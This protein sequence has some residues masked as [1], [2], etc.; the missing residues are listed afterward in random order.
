VIID[1]RSAIPP[2]TCNT[3]SQFKLNL[4]CTTKATRDAFGN[5]ILEAIAESFPVL[6]GEG[7]SFSYAVVKP[8]CQRV[9]H[10]HT[11]PGE[12]AL[13][14]QGTASIG[15]FSFATANQESVPY[16]F[17]ASAGDIWFFPTGYL[18]YITNLDPPGGQDVIAVLG[19]SYDS[20]LAIT[21]AQ[22]LKP[23]PEDVIALS[24]NAQNDAFQ[25]WKL[26]DDAFTCINK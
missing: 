21:A 4:A 18:Q 13:V 14:L 17:N 10:W 23:L 19:F 26:H 20:I 3:T 2:S 6:E 22:G 1:R 11:I 24:L 8:G 16:L 12:L 25:K 7:L 5:E 9:L 15:L